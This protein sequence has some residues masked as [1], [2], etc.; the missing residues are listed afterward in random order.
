MLILNV[1]F[2]EKDEVKK[3]GARWNPDIKKWYIH[4]REDYYKFAKWMILLTKMVM[5]VENMQT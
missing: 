5:N 3:L 1:P 2:N 4:K